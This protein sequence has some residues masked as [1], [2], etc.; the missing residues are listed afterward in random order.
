MRQQS[1]DLRKLLAAE[2]DGQSAAAPASIFAEVGAPPAPSAGLDEGEFGPCPTSAS[3][4]AIFMR[5]LEEAWATTMAEMAEGTADIGTFMETF[6]TLQQQLHRIKA[7]SLVARVKLTS[8]S[9]SNGP[10][11]PYLAAVTGEDASG[12]EFPDFDEELEPSYGPKGTTTA[13]GATD[14]L[15]VAGAVD[16]A[17]TPFGVM[18]QSV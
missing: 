3:D 11:G 16:T 12:D 2:A 15:V 6:T 1:I 18:P 9:N 7:L 5:G 14:T 17:G 8:V 13:R 4:I 10:K